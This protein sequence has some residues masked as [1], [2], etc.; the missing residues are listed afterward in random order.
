MKQ[1]CIAI[2]SLFITV[3]TFAA[4]QDAIAYNDKIIKEQNKIGEAMLIFSN[5]PNE[6]SLSSI[7]TQI[8]KGMSV[9]NTMKPFEG[10]KKFLQAAKALFKF[11]NSIVKNEYQ[12][13]LTLMVNNKNYSQDALT[14][15]IDEVTHSI[16]KKEIAY[17]KAFQAA[18]KEFA[19][20]YGF[21]L[22]KN[23]LLEK[24]STNNNED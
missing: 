2:F 10:N 16:S 22:Q 24:Y 3:N 20:K 18:Q 21:I 17:D 13:I 4:N 15:K 6:F 14:K 1:F 19:L 5:N 9:L 7:N 11:Y 23:N 8:Y 12:K